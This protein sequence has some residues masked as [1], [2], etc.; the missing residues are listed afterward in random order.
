MSKSLFL[1][2]GNQGVNDNLTRFLS[3]SGNF[4]ANATEVNIEL[5]IRDAGVFN[6]LYVYVSA[7]TCSVDS[8][9]DLRVNQASP[10]GTLTVTFGADE[11]GIKEDTA[12]SVTVAATDEIN[13]RI[14]IPTE[15]GTNT[16]TIKVMG[17]EFTP[18][19]SGDCVSLLS[20]IPVSGAFATASVTYFTV[21][22]G[23][24]AFELTEANYKYRIRG[25]FTASDFYAYVTSNTRTTDTIFGTR[26]NGANGSQSVTYIASETGAKQDTTNTDSLAAGDDYNY[27][28]T[29]STGTGTIS[30]LNLSSSLISAANQFVL[31]CGR[32][33]GAAV[34]FN[35]TAYFGCAGDLLAHATENFYKIYPRFTFTAKELGVYVS[36]NTITT[37]PSVITVRDNG[38][39]SPITV[40]Y[41]AAETGL[42]TDTS[43]TA[44]IT[45]VTD[46]IAYQLVTPNTSG[47]ITLR[48]IGMM[49]DTSAAGPPPFPLFKRRETTLIRM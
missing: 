45:S 37:D 22:N 24:R 13:Y 31:L 15:A 3:V 38:V 35:A 49:G 8:V 11:T 25:T 46:E 4:A 40:S 14:V 20:S 26:K 44:E 6:N 36:A 12:N 34:N 27:H 18:T 7:N 5:P 19:A 21:P 32:D 42:K 2:I 23:Q 28:I 16:I 47:T 41:A 39:N 48:W 43:N 30:V 29:T 9:I 1:N 33:V 17:M 10:G